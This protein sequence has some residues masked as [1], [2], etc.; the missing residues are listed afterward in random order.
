MESSLGRFDPE[1]HRNNVYDAFSEFVETFRYEYEAVAKDPPTSLN[2]DA[3]I[4]WIKKDMRKLFLGKYAS[5][6]FQKDY[7]ATVS[8]EE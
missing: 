7:E 1:V 8:A 4:E 3:Q 5:R 2:N 6:N